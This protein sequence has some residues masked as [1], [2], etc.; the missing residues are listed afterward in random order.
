MGRCAH[1][2][3]SNMSTYLDQGHRVQALR[4]KV[5]I[6][7]GFT[8]LWQKVEEYKV[9][10]IQNVF[11]EKQLKQSREMYIKRKWLGGVREVTH[12]RAAYWSRVVFG[13]DIVRTPQ[14]ASWNVRNIP[15]STV[16]LLS[17]CKQGQ[18]C[19]RVFVRDR[20]I[21][22]SIKTKTSILSCSDSSNIYYLPN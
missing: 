2:G 9:Q 6:S 15:G 22:Y 14:H 8:T 11:P 7:L 17:Y 16:L 1:L 21:K 18:V 10:S 12:P 20:Q 19:A 4:D 5:P 3:A 13:S